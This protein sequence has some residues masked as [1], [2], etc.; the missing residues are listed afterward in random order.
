MKRK[1][2]KN[3]PTKKKILIKK[4]RRKIIEQEIVNQ[5]HQHN[6]IINKLQDQTKIKYK[7]QGQIK[8]WQWVLSSIGTEPSDQSGESV[9]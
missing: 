4:L 8:N 2:Q 7:A 1:I 6:K 3:W 5:I 9:F